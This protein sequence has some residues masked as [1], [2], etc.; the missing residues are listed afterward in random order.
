[1][2]IFDFN[3]SKTFE[4]SIIKKF[5]YSIKSDSSGFWVKVLS[6]NVPSGAPHNYI[7]DVM[8]YYFHSHPWAGTLYV[9]LWDNNG[10]GTFR[11]RGSELIHDRFI[12]ARK[13]HT[14]DIWFLNVDGNGLNGVKGTVEFESIGQARSNVWHPVSNEEQTIKPATNPDWSE[15]N[16]YAQPTLLN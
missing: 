10:L 4:Y 14:F 3:G 11:Y 16:S 6:A 9:A 15:Y 2:F 7:F 5:F 13:E 12:I 8:A 1:M